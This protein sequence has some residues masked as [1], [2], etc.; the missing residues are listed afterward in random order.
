M[1]KRGSQVWLGAGSVEGGWG[2]GLFAPPPRL[3]LE[4]ASS[5]CSAWGQLTTLL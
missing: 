3:E 1:D 2:W 5:Y 4:S